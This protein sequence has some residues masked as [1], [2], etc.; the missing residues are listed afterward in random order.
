MTKL[1]PTQ[2]KFRKRILKMMQNYFLN[3]THKMEEISRKDAV[4]LIIYFSSLNEICLGK[5]NKELLS[6]LF[7]INPV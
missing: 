4:N 1:P 3:I 2:N 7:K 5:F 6:T